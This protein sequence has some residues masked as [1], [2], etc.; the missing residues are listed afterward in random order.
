MQALLTTIANPDTDAQTLAQTVRA[1]GPA[2]EDPRF[3]SVIANSDHYRPD[4]RRRAALSLFERHLRPPIT[5]GQLA[6]ALD[7]PTWLDDESIDVVRELGGLVPVTVEP[8]DTVFA[9]RLFSQ[10][11]ID[12]RGVWAVYLR[13]QG[14][15]ELEVLRNAVQGR[16]VD[17]DVLGRQ[18]LEVGFS[19]GDQ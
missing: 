7:K 16:E 3:W 4:H 17:A 2:T 5:L 18:V 14:K 12:R 1:L 10:L 9:L 19:A 8:R 6:R 11:S 15:L 13:V